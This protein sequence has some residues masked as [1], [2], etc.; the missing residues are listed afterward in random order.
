MWKRL[1]T[2]NRKPP[3]PL[4]RWCH[5]SYNKTCRTD[6]KTDLA[7]IDNSG[8]MTGLCLKEPNRCSCQTHQ[9]TNTFLCENCRLQ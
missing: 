4:G 3:V 7:N 2:F 8:P 9:H 1:F 6:I 5:K